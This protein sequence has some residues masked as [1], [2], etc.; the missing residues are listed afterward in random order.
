[1]DSFIV[2]LFSA[3]GYNDGMLATVPQ[4][5][6]N[7]HFGG[8]ENDKESIPDFLVM[9]ILSDVKMVIV[10]DNNTSL[11]TCNSFPQLFADIIAMFATNEA[12]DK[13]TKKARIEESAPSKES[14]VAEPLA[15]GVRVN[16]SVFH[17]HGVGRSP[18]V[19]RAMDTLQA[20][21]DP[22][23]TIRLGDENGLEFMFPEQRKQI[24][25]ILNK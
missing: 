12:K 22:T 10:E 24:I 19:L 6:M 8:N 17:F 11:V 3:L 4:F 16:G 23:V 9:D 7:L 1:M 20:T 21:S 13:G 14:V 5:K 18:E 25:Y 15:L 2:Q